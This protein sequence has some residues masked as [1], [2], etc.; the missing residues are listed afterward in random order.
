MASPKLPRARRPVV[1]ERVQEGGRWRDPGAAPTGLTAWVVAAPLRA[2]AVYCAVAVVL[3]V[4][5]TVWPGRLLGGS[6]AMAA[7][8]TLHTT[9][10][11]H[12]YL[13]WGYGRT[14]QLRAFVWLGY[15][16]GTTAFAVA[17]ASL[18]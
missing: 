17:A 7:G 18:L 4:A 6:A 9:T 10:I 12:H 3:A 1:A 13:T 15:G 16:L 5:A 8:V 2:V 14:E 11:G